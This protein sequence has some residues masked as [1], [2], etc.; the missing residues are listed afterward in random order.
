[1]AA[2]GVWLVLLLSF[3]IAATLTPLV[4]DTAR[5]NGLFDHALSSRKVHGRPTPRVGGIAIVFAFYAAVT[6]AMLW[7]PLQAELSAAPGESAIRTSTLLA[8][9]IAI[10]VLGLYDDLK[11]AGAKQ[12]FTVQFAVAG[13]VYAAGLRIEIVA[14]PFGG[15]LALGWLSLPL[16]LLW[17]AGAMNAM[18]LMDGLDGLA[19]GIAI[20]AAAMTIAA[21]AHTDHLFAVISAAALAGA[22]GGFLV[23]NISPASIFMGDSGSMFLGYVL[24]TSA[25][26]PQHHTGEIP[27]FAF[28]VALGIPIAD[29]LAAVVRRALRGAP[30][31]VADREHV[32]HRLLD[33]GLAPRQASLILWALAALLAGAGMTLAGCSPGTLL[34]AVA[35]SFALG[36]HQ[37][38][39]LHL[40]SLAA[41][42][43]RRRRNLERRRA[44]RVAGERLRRARRVAD[45][46]EPLQA[47][48]PALG[49][50]GIWLHIDAE[51]MT[52]ERA[53]VCVGPVAQA[54]PLFRTMHGILG[55]HPGAG[56]IEVAWNDGRTSLDRDSEIAIELLCGHVGAALRR[57]ERA[58]PRR[59]GWFHEM[60]A[61]SHEMQ[62][63]PVAQNARN[64]PVGESVDHASPG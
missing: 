63:T 62:P 7:P 26:Q 22:V 27:F 8:G 19:G 9:G 52:G 20:A 44:I 15:A 29:T 1:M 48:G 35:V 40:Q 31:F 43:A 50:Q 34:V 47:I 55:E 28:L 59:A 6:A 41:L 45:L 42:L 16:T 10:F 39:C 60:R 23:Y 12:K 4:R 21:G 37:L 61:R 54:H 46:L 25:I 3:A 58:A 24:A 30:L 2:V 5:R 56:S 32:H 57:I 38:G 53:L 18:N 11:G 51:G 64:S 36:L 49:A 14:N 17:I 13:L 33:L